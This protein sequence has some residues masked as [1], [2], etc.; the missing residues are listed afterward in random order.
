MQRDPAAFH[1]TRRQLPRNG[2]MGTE[3]F[4]RGT[5][6]TLPYT[7]SMVFTSERNGI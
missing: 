6:V 4:R 3:L 5:P 7:F 2:L 1:K